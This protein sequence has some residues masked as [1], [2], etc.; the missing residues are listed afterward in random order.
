MNPSTYRILRGG[1]LVSQKQIYN[2]F[3]NSIFKQILL[4]A[5]LSIVWKKSPSI[6]KEGETPFWYPITKFVQIN[7]KTPL[8]IGILRGFFISPLEKFSIEN[9]LEKLTPYQTLYL[10]LY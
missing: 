8:S 10:A 9:F 5:T 7:L 3:T 6:I 2:V 1:L 4:E